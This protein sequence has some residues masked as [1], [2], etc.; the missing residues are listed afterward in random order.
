MPQLEG[1]IKRRRLLAAVAAAGLAAGTS[2]AAGAVTSAAAAAP[3]SPQATKFRVTSFE[4]D[5]HQKR[6]R[7]STHK[8]LTF[9]VFINNQTSTPLADAA[10]P[11]ASL[12][13][14]LS[15][16][17]GSGVVLAARPKTNATGTVARS[18]GTQESHEWTF[19]VKRSSLRINAKKGTGTV[20][21]KKQLK[22]YGKFR[23]KM[24][25]AGKAHRS[26]PA[27]T[28]FI[29][30]RKVTL[31]GTPRFNS[32]SGKHGWG[33]VGRHRTK[34]K[35]TL[36]VDFGTPGSSCGRPIVAHCS[37]VGISVDSFPGLTEVSASGAPGKP[38]RIT[39][40]RQV[41]LSSPSGAVRFDF[42]GGRAK[43]LK[44]TRDAEGNLKFRISPRSN[45][46]SGSATVTAAPPP[47]TSTCKRTSTDVYFGATWAN[48]AKK[49]TMRG[50]IE[51]RIRIKNNRSADA[52]VTTRRA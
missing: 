41:H 5:S 12:T 19:G 40:F 44:A 17:S 38:A 16:Q 3:A 4:I 48:G 39:A 31:V 30:T 34:L 7:S 45:N 24:A 23:L 27:S 1:S 11:A 49:F 29:S 15:R 32:K 10:T 21:S 6:V 33:V 51:K 36:I 25:P 18:T 13:V 8:R 50:Q 14:G 20:K 22:G 9:F 52:Q 35:A 47:G 46:A 42:L 37:S 26:C 2:L 28:G 43:P